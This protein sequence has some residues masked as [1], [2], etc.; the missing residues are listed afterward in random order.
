MRSMTVFIPLKW[1]AGLELIHYRAFHF[2][3]KRVMYLQFTRYNVIL[4]GLKWTFY[5]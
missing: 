4:H 1:I 3:C 5:T 2:G